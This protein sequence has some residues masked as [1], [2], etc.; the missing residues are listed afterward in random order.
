MR[1]ITIR[2]DCRDDDRYAD[3]ANALWA[4]MN[5]TGCDFTVALGT[6]ADATAADKRWDHY[7]KVSW[8]YGGRR[9]TPQAFAAGDSRA[10]TSHE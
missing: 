9:G 2:F 8:E 4:Q 7:S 6:D 1:E 10:D 3:I 5:A